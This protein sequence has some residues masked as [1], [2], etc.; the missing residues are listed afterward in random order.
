MEE[1]HTRIV[2]QCL[3]RKPSRCKSDRVRFTSLIDLIAFKESARKKKKR[4]TERE[5]ERET[6]RERERERERERAQAQQHQSTEPSDLSKGAPSGHRSQFLF[7]A[8]ML[9]FFAIVRN[10]SLWVELNTVALLCTVQAHHC[11]N[12]AV[13]MCRADQSSQL[14]AI[15]RGVGQL[16]PE[17][18]GPACMAAQQRRPVSRCTTQL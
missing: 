15:P 6:Q 12:L 2:L 1:A 3:A 18:Q 11:A 5:T 17:M 7:H 10:V 8:Q 9:D 13:E 16:G 4:E 14:Y